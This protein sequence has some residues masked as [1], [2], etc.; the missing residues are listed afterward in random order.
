MK[1]IVCKQLG[2]PEQLAFEDVTLPAVKPT[3]VKI[4]IKGAGVNFPDTLI[5]QGKYQLKATPPFTPGGEVAGVVLE[6]GE[7]VKHLRAG[8][9]VAALVPTGAYAE[10][11]IAPADGVMPLPRGMDF[12]DAAAFPFVYGTTIHALKQRGQLK[13]GETL[14]VLGA[15]GGVGLAAVQLGKLMGAK[16]IAAASSPEKLEVCKQ[17]GADMLIDY[18]K[19]SL[20]EEI[21][22][23]TKGQ[24][25]DVIYDPVGGALG[26]ECLSCIAWNGRYLVIGFASGP[27]PNLAANR[28][29]LKGAAAVGVFWG[30]FVMREPKANWENFQQ[31]FQ[32][33]GEG[34]LKPYISQTAPLADA[35]KILREMMER[36]VTGKVV[37]TP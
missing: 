29:L 4:Q 17:H 1:A 32:W 22:K 2:M 26:E 20:K 27:I 34:R 36:K 13:S 18:S 30:A 35:P 25:A 5:I 9:A 7:K 21:K 28:L 12:K 37:L 15:S 31:L 16:V 19:T 33:Y 10:E 3:E 11:V 6:V 8:D 24:G 14:L 23:L